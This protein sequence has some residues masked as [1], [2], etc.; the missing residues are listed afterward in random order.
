[1]IFSSRFRAPTFLRSQFAPHG[2]FQCFDEFRRARRPAGVS[3]ARIAAC[4]SAQ[5]CVAR[6]VRQV[7]WIQCS[8]RIL[9]SSMAS[10]I[11]IDEPFSV[12]SQG[13]LPSVSARCSVVRYVD[14]NDSSQTCHA[15]SIFR[16]SAITV[17]QVHRAAATDPSMEEPVT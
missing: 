14:S 7:A 12:G 15:E 17:T 13:E 2:L 4:S 10:A 1:M 9:I 11:E 5:L 3:A 16:P 6:Y 8:C